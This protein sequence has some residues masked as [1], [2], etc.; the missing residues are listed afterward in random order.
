[1]TIKDLKNLCP[2]CKSND[3]SKIAVI[4]GKNRYICNNKDCTEK[5]EKD[6]NKTFYID[7]DSNDSKSKDMLDTNEFKKICPYCKSND[8]SKIAVINGKNRYI[9]NNK[10][11]TE[12][13]EKDRNKTFYI[14][15][16]SNDSKSKDM[17]DTNEFKKICPY[18]KSNDISKIAVING[19]NRYICNNKDCTEKTEKD[20]NKT[21]YLE[22]KVK[23]ECPICRSTRVHKNGFGKNNNI[24][25]RCKDCEKTE[26]EKPKENRKPYWFYEND[27]KQ[28][29]K[30][31]EESKESIEIIGGINEETKE[32]KFGSEYLKNLEL[33][34]KSI[35]SDNK[36]KHE[37]EP[38]FQDTYMKP[39]EFN[40]EENKLKRRFKEQLKS[41]KDKYNVK[42]VNEEYEPGDSPELV[43]ARKECIDCRDKY[44]NDYESLKRQLYNSFKELEN[45]LKNKEEK[46]MFW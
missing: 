30:L 6:R 11:C 39:E 14:D 5:T 1:M 21:F 23:V 7:N 28:K 40:K 33:K 9:C 17:L 38:F 18:C 36:D 12:K 42:A 10:D 45:K 46:F 16:D 2:Y 26:K 13:T 19:K 24:R 44:E 37:N 8:I 3:I 27:I 4:N 43:Q 20:R 31:K 29:V 15:N 25:Y 22:K 32:E 41:I 34:E 35:N